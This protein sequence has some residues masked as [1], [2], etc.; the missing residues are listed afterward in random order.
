[1]DGKLSIPMAYLI[2]PSRGGFEH[3]NFK[4][5]DGEWQAGCGPEPKWGR[6]DK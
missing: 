2:G 3:E 6:E 4:M 1:M 5:K